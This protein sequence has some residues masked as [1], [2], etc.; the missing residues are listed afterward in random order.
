MSN[1]DTSAAGLRA[2][3]HELET[4]PGDGVIA[5][6]IEALRALAA[7]KE[8]LEGIQSEFAPEKF[9]GIADSLYAMS[10]EMRRLRAEL[11]KKEMG[12]VYKAFA[13]HQPA[14]PLPDVDSLAH[15]MWAAA[16]LAPG[17]GVE[18]GA[19]RLTKILQRVMPS[20]PL[21]TGAVPEQAPLDPDIAKIVHD[22]LWELYGQESLTA[23]PEAPQAAVRGPLVITEIHG[24]SGSTMMSHPSHYTEVR[25]KFNCVKDAEVFH[26]QIAGITGTQ[27]AGND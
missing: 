9:G 23:A 21:D 26:A 20:A 3:A 19:G 18:D 25:V 24:Y 22:N 11:V 13:A 2:I 10:A 5:G 8:V 12:P 27:E 16:Q 17:E 7:E 15:E 4:F 6:A 1:I 14:A